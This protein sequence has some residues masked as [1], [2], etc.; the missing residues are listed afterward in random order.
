MNTRRRVCLLAL[1]ALFAVA[2]APQAAPAAKPKCDQNYVPTPSQ[3]EWTPMFFVGR[4]GIRI[5][6]PKRL[7]NGAYLSPEAIQA[8]VLGLNAS[9]W[10]R[11]CYVTVDEQGIRSGNDDE[12]IERNLRVLDKALD[13]VGVKV[14]VI[15]SA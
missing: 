1:S 12:F 15:V 11:G 13:A 8:L 5:L 4:E 10:T 9:D 3:A 14:G 7:D 2:A 6:I